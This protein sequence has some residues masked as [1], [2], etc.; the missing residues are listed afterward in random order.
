[1]EGCI[2]EMNGTDASKYG[3]LA[4][5]LGRKLNLQVILVFVQFLYLLN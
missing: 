4:Y 3:Q 5:K 2:V 1:M